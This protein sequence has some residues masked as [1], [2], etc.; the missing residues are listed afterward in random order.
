[1]T[2]N[3]KIH[4]KQA[5]DNDDDFLSFLKQEVRSEGYSPEKQAEIISHSEREM[6]YDYVTEQ[7]N[8]SDDR[9][10]R[11]HISDCKI[12]AREVFNIRIFEDN[13][14]KE[15]MEWADRMPVKGWIIQFL[16]DLKESLFGRPI[17]WASGFGMAAACLM[18][19]FL[20]PG[21][22]QSDLSKLIAQSYDTAIMEKI[23]F[24]TG[25]PGSGSLAF[26]SSEKNVSARA[27]RAG[28]WTGRQTLSKDIS[29]KKPD[30]LS[31][32]WQGDTQ[33]TADKW[34]DTPWAVYFQMGRWCF[35]MQSVC[36]SENRG[37]E[38]YWDKQTDILNAIQIA[39]KETSEKNQE[40]ARFINLRLNNI[41]AVLEK[42]GQKIP[43]I[44]Q[45]R[46]INKEIS[47]FIEYMVPGIS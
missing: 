35:L 39:F 11:D 9:K 4:L 15:D 26:N 13:M 8:D 12:C 38:S 28:L 17:Y 37:T 27:F 16:S 43:G 32:K 21:Q 41:S 46:S 25:F 29:V 5:L 34:T 42:S 31:P 20:I 19:F 40:D 10:V 3:E 24:E 22:K 33:I 23:P 6:L 45:C 7:L 30:F 36:M 14:E 47:T 1:M 44:F 2:T 18:L